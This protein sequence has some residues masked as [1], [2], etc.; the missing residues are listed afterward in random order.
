MTLSSGEESGILSSEAAPAEVPSPLPLSAEV[1]PAFAAFRKVQVG[2]P[3]KSRTT[4]IAPSIIW[5]LIALSLLVRLSN[6]HSPLLEVHHFRQ[7]QTAFTVW[8][9][10]QSGSDL[11]H[12]M[13]PVFGPPWMLPFEF[14]IFQATATLLIRLTRID[15]DAGCRL[16]NILYFY[17]SAGVLYLLARKLFQR[18]SIAVC[19]VL[20]YLWTPFSVVWSRTSMIEFAAATFGLAY[21]YFT[22]LWLESRRNLAYPIIAVAMGCLGALTKITSMLPFVPLLLSLPAAAIWS[23]MRRNDATPGLSA[24]NRFVRRFDR[25][26]SLSRWRSFCTSFPSR[27]ARRG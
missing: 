24:F 7:T 19:V 20:F 21:V 16:T 12:P 3:Q 17:A 4:W 1:K 11:M 9:Y 5:L 15:I 25:T 2:L 6:L 22:V 27:L 13:M 18:R 10:L 14:P 26:G 23:D 8:C